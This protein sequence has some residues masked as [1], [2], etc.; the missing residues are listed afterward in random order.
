MFS[1]AASVAAGSSARVMHLARF[2]DDPD[3]AVAGNP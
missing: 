1:S 3:L 2:L